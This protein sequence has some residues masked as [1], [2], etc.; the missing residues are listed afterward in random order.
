MSRPVFRLSLGILTLAALLTAAPSPAGAQSRRPV[1]TGTASAWLARLWCGVPLAWGKAGCK[2]DPNGI[3]NPNKNGCRVD[4]D[5]TGTPN[6]AGCSVDPNG[7][8]IQ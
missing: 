7:R 6:K 3:E 5:G 8:C 4:P 1:A 2:A